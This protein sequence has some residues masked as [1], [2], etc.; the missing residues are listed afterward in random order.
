MTLSL[1]PLVLCASLFA[2]FTPFAAHAEGRSIIVLDASGSMWGQI[3]GRPKLEIARAALA[4]RPIEVKDPLAARLRAL[5]DGVDD[6]EAKVRALL[7]VR[8]VFE[9]GL[10]ALLEPRV[11]AAYRTLTATGARAS[12]AAIG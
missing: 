5:S 9:P 11:T 6:P 2:A 7:S 12:V 8:E 1:K 4:G 10:A 3:E